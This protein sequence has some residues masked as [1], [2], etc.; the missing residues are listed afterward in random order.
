[1]VRSHLKERLLRL[2]LDRRRLGGK[3]RGG[4]RAHSR[5]LVFPAREPKPLGGK[6]RE[7]EPR[8]VVAQEPK[9]PELRG[10][11]QIAVARCGVPG[12]GKGG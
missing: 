7:G 5:A 9:K 6:A 10:T 8:H 1:M 11:R 12:A 3:V 2:A 4:K